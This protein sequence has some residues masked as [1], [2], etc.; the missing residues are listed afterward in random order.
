MFSVEQ[1]V[2]INR[3]V[4]EVFAYV[5]DVERWD[6]WAAE[7]VEAKKTSEGPVGAGTTFSAVIKMLGR[8][9]E[10]E[11]EVTEYEPNSRFGIRVTSGPVSGEGGLSFE[12]VNPGTKVTMAIE[13][14]TGGFFKLA[15]PLVARQANRQYETNLATMK[16]LLEAQASEST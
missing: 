5:S 1:S 15:E 12:S 3:P 14:E 11:H 2:V 6:E 7:I 9:M 10:N 16:D 8:R 13:A 4:G